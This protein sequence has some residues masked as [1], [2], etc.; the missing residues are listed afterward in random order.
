MDN[1]KTSFGK[2]KVKENQKTKMVQNV[3]SEVPKK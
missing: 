1:L 3:F 2:Q